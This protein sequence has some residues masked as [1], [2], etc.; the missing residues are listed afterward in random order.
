LSTTWLSP[1]HLDALHTAAKTTT[2]LEVGRALRECLFALTQDFNRE[3]LQVAV[4][5]LEADP[6]PPLLE[7]ELRDLQQ[8]L[9]KGVQHN[10]VI[11]KLSSLEVARALQIAADL[12]QRARMGQLDFEDQAGL[13]WVF[14][15][16]AEA[17]NG[18]NH[19]SVRRVEEVVRAGLGL[20]IR[21]DLLPPINEDP[22]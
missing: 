7:D 12:Q 3:L 6:M 5:A 13:E 21:L 17:D 18:I 8:L 22:A 4:A 16:A 19:N 11:P 10:G 9:V 20:G 15:V 1:R 14:D 2:D